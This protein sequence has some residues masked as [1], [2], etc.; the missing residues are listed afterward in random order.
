MSDKNLHCEKMQAAEPE[1]LTS[2]PSA[3]LKSAECISGAYYQAW[4]KS[5]RSWTCTATFSPCSCG[6]RSLLISV[7]HHTVGD[8]AL[9]LTFIPNT[10]CGCPI[11][12]G[13]P[14][15]N[16]CLTCSQPQRVGLHDSQPSHSSL[17]RRVGD[18]TSTLTFIPK[19][20]CG[21]PILCGP[22]ICSTYPNAC[23]RKGWVYKLPTLTFIPDTKCGCPILCGPHFR[24]TYPTDCGR[25]GWVYK[26]SN[27]HIHP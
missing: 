12:C 11:L 4:R 8:R 7:P 18:R 9:T 23:R 24:P 3:N 15:C 10:K 5:P 17:A 20:K 25:K 14:I 13:L 2:S 6:R 21:C 1:R 27:P 26:T 16:E 22:P 19:T